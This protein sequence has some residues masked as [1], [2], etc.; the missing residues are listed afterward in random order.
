MS[1]EPKQSTKTRPWQYELSP[2]GTMLSKGSGAIDLENTTISLP[3]LDRKL[4]A[5]LTEDSATLKPMVTLEPLDGFISMLASRSRPPKLITQIETSTARLSSREHAYFEVRLFVFMAVAKAEVEAA[6]MR[7]RATDIKAA[8]KANLRSSQKLAQITN[9]LCYKNYY[10]VRMIREIEKTITVMRKEADILKTESREVLSGSG[11]PDIWKIT[12][13]ELLGIGWSVLTGKAPSAGTGE[14]SFG[15]FVEV[16]YETVAPN[17]PYATWES[18]I[19]TAKAFSKRKR[20]NDPW[21]ER[22][23]AKLHHLA[24]HITKEPKRS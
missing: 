15:R 14:A 2:L 6:I 19:K 21:R 18:Q 5:Y 10:S 9:E 16:A 4:F 13:V 1:K 17:R 3:E 12:F 20:P 11:N 23:W 22:R 8:L 24:P 7:R